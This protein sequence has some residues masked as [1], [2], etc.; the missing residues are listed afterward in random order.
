[1][2]YSAYYHAHQLLCETQQELIYLNLKFSNEWLLL[3][4]S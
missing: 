2:F 4:S 1:M 3:R